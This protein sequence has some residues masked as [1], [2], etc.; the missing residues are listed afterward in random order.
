MRT[1][2]P[3]GQNPDQALREIDEIHGT[4]FSSPLDEEVM[5]E[6]RADWT[7][8]NEKDANAP[9]LAERAAVARRALAAG[10]TMHETARMFEV[11]PIEI[12][13][14]FVTNDAKGGAVLTAER[15]LRGGCYSHAA[16]ARHLKVSSQTVDRIA[17]LIGIKSVVAERRAEGGGDKY[18]AEQ[19]AKIRELHVQGYSHGEKAAMT[20]MNV[21]AIKSYCLRHQAKWTTA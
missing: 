17:E 18:T 2:C 7:E 10:L 21:N 8:L 1:L 14:L 19:L 4:N 11:R 12:A 16:V 15:M 3:R 5:G 13:R 20:G 6:L 9:Q